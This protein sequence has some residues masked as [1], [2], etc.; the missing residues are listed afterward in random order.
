[1]KEQVA[2]LQSW[3]KLTL[4][5][6]I[7]ELEKRGFECAAPISS[8]KKVTKLWNYRRENYQAYRRDFKGTADHVLHK[9]KMIRKESKS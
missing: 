9:V 4:V 7:Q 8:T 1:M 2:I 3:D 6:R 5:K